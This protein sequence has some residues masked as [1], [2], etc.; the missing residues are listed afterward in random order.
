[1]AIVTRIDPSTPPD[2]VACFYG[3]PFCGKPIEYELF[4]DFDE[5]RFNRVAVYFKEYEFTEK[6]IHGI[7][8]E[9]VE[10]LEEPCKAIGL[11]RCLIPSHWLDTK[12]YVAYTVAPLSDNLSKTYGVYI[13]SEKTDIRDIMFEIYYRDYEFADLISRK[14]S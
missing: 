6:L 13:A 9:I 5:V 1:M 2:E 7:L 11:L 3:A 12:N 10:M 8:S 4:D 14:L